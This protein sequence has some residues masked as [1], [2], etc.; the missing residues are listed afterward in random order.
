MATT[1]VVVSRK[2]ERQFDP[3]RATEV[4]SAGDGTIQFHRVEDAQKGEVRLHCHSPA[5]EQKGRA[6]DDAK[7]AGFEASLEKIAAALS[8]PAAMNPYLVVDK[9]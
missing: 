2:R 8:Q 7:S 9:A 1:Y 6:I 5:R 3:E 4:Q